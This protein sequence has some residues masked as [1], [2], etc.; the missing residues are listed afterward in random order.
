MTTVGRQRGRPPMSA[1]R[2]QLPATIVPAAVHDALIKEAAVREVS[3][4]QV[5]REAMISYL[6]Q[7][8]AVNTPV[9][10]DH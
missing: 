7:R 8:P 6:E 3:V 10:S 1:V 4:C 5:V 2:S 9:S